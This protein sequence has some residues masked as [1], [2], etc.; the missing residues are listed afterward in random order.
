MQAARDLGDAGVDNVYGAG[1]LQLPKPPDVVAPTATA[2]ASAGRSGKMLR[3]L[4]KVSDDS[5]EVSIVEQIKL[6]RKTIATIK[7]AGFVFAATAKTFAT[8]W[9]APKKVAGSY[10]HCVRV[11][12]RTGNAS[13]LSCAKVVLK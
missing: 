8:L 6:G 11:T 13:P 7:R 1:E 2:L 10:Q 9:K 12:D 3:L 5:G 4:A